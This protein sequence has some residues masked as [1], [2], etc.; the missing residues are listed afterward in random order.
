MTM[1]GSWP[2][3]PSFGRTLLCWFGSLALAGSVLVVYFR[4]P[5]LPLVMAGGLTLLLTMLRYWWAHRGP[6]S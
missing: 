5:W 6:N 2:P 1:G 4:M 3:R